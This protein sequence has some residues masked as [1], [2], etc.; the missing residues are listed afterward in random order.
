MVGG[1][2][3]GAAV[4]GGTVM[5]TAAGMARG[6]VVPTGMNF[7]AAASTVFGLWIEECRPDDEAPDADCVVTSARATATASTVLTIAPTMRGWFLS[8]VISRAD[9]TCL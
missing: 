7:F 5:V 1:A 6:R 3:T 8:E 4:V 2:V 9:L